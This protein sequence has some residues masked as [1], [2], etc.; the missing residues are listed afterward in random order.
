MLKKTTLLLCIAIA[1]LLHVF[2]FTFVSFYFKSASTPFLLSWPSIL[3]STDLLVINKP[4]KFD[5]AVNFKRASN[6]DKSY[7]LTSLEKPSVTVESAA[8]FDAARKL[9]ESIQ[10]IPAC[11]IKETDYIYMWEKPKSLIDWEK[12]T[13]QYKAFVSPYGKVILSFPTKLPVNSSAN[14]SSQDYTRQA[15]LFLKD[16]FLWTKVEAVVR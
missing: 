14:L 6:L 5:K 15:A 2:L 7:F 11:E 3:T 1:L 8:A 12:E 10:P 16:K 13:I 4:V 9:P